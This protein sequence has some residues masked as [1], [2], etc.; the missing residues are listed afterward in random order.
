MLLD[1]RG[2]FIGGNAEDSAKAAVHLSGGLVDFLGERKFWGTLF[3][4]LSIVSP[5]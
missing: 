3:V 4:L 5:N 2:D 1:L